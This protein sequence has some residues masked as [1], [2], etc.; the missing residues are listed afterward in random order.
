VSTQLAIL[1][2]N[3]ACFTIQFLSEVTI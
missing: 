3:F 2:V 1:M